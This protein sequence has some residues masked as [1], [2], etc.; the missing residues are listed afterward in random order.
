MILYF[1][2]QFGIF[3][4]CT[5]IQLLRKFHLGFS[6]TSKEVYRLLYYKGNPQGLSCVVKK[7]IKINCITGEILA[8][9]SLVSIS[10][11]LDLMY[12]LVDM[13]ANL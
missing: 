8:F 6:H 2:T 7:E 3:E 4:L 1:S 5:N 13:K 10:N 9:F 11:H 12:F